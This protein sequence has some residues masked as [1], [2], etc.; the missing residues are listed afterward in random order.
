MNSERR[1]TRAIGVAALA[2]I[3]VVVALVA[4]TSVYLMSGSGGVQ[5]PST[6][7]STSITRTLSSATSTISQTSTSAV[8]PASGLE[9]SLTLNVTDVSAGHGIA[10]T[11]EEANMGTAPLNVSAS[12]DWPIQGLA[13]GPCGSL[14]YPVGIAVLSGNY[15][16]ANVSSSVALQI[17]EPAVYACP[18][19]LTGIGG[20]LF[21][22]SSDN[23][24]VYGSCQ[25]GPCLNE[26]ISA[27]VSA[28]GYWAGSIST[29]FTSFPTGVYTVVGGDEWGGI[30]ILHF[31]VTGSGA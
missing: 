15:D 21:Q 20:Y 22:A 5:P 23:A 4:G 19:V 28:S 3:L 1:A 16:V 26:T 29:T 25:P 7:S 2:G 8:S 24:T 6:T 9:L 14:N 11:V 17:Y 13:V 30:A 12:K 27:T 31:A 10:A 18:M